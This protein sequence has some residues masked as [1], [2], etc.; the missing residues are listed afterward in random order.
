MGVFIMKEKIGEVLGVIFEHKAFYYGTFALGIFAI[1]LMQYLAF[2]LY[3]RQL[4]VLVVSH[5][6]LD[7][8]ALDAWSIL[9]VYGLYHFRKLNKEYH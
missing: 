9:M 7:I 3:G 4:N 6:Q 5:Y 1:V 8:L 2:H